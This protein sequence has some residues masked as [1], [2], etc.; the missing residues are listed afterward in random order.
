MWIARTFFASLA[1]IIL[2]G[3]TY[4]PTQDEITYGR[5]GEAPDQTKAEERAKSF[6]D[7]HLKDPESARYQFSQAYK[8]WM[9]SNR[10]EGSIFYAGYIVEAKVNA[11]NTLGGYTGWNIYR[12]L[13]NGGAL[14][15]VVLISPQGV[16]RT[17][18]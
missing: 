6:F 12:L 18:L 17:M 11:K 1:F 8:G 4:G 3:C 5:Y 13:F 7:D 2:A 16:E 14:V 15:R 9:Y 10:F